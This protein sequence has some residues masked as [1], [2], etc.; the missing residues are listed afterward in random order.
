M[1]SLNIINHNDNQYYLATDLY[2]YDPVYFGN[3]NKRSDIIKK[4]KLKET[5]YIYAYEKNGKWNTSDI[6]YKISKI[7]IKKTW[8]ENNV[9]KLKINDQNID[10]NE[11]Y[12]I[13]LAPELLE[14]NDEEKFRDRDGNIIE[15]EVRGERHF[16][17]CYFKV[18]DIA[19]S[20]KM[21]SLERVIINNRTLDGYMEEEHYKYFNIQ[22]DVS[23]E[24]TAI[25]K[26]MFLTYEGMIRL[27]YIS[28]SP[29]AA[30]FRKW[31]SEKLFTI[32]IGSEDDKLELVKSMFGGAS[33]R[34]IKETFKV[35]SDKTPC[36]YLYVIG[37]AEQLLKCEIYKD[38]L[39]LKYGFT[40][41]LPR[42]SSE[43]ERAFKKLFGI[44][45]IE[46]ICYSVIDPKY[47]SDAEKSISH[48]FNGDK[49][50]YKDYKELIV[51][52]SNDIEKAK[53]HY[54][55]V[56]NSYIGCYCEMQD[57]INKLEQNLRDKD[58]E[59]KLKD[60]DN[61]L[62][63]KDKDLEIMMLKNQMLEYQ[64][65]NLIPLR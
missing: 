30:Y 32:Q 56:K 14:L 64:V 22:K 55:L 26:K 7:L 57:R 18:K 1:N 33:V 63:I 60:K 54:R 29:N 43:H 44:D 19:N 40:D 46:L 53:E 47:I 50:V 48:Y 10:I 21:S 24:K 16:E 5:D 23:H 12:T 35:C 9:P 49:I 37:Y 3:I 39:I 61:E 58:N 31:A 28:R 11:L 38:K 51:L 65:K 4:V 13:P 2:L 15:I 36:V 59:L 6:S 41:D 8:A 25:K 52:N 34:A 20:F 27:L 17:K 62:K 45:H 42:R